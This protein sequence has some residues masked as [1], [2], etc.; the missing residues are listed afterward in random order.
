[1]VQEILWDEHVLGQDSLVIC[2][3][4][5]EFEIFTRH[6]SR[7]IKRAVVYKNLDKGEGP[8]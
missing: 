3:R 4:Y 7:N 1:M 2:N 6:S 5:S 8:G